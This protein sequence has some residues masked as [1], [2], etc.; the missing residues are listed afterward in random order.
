MTAQL[1]A[2]EWAKCAV[3]DRLQFCKGAELLIRSA[4]A[5]HFF[6]DFLDTLQRTAREPEGRTLKK[7][8]FPREREEV[9]RGSRRRW[10]HLSRICSLSQQNR[11]IFTDSS[12]ALIWQYFC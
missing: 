10:N 4:V 1:F 7:G 6:H 3:I 5:H 12:A 11:K 9:F 8:S 2:S